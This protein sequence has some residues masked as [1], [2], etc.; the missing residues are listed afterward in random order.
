VT[1]TLR[2]VCALGSV[3]VAGEARAQDVTF[4]RDVAP[5]VFEACAP[6]HRP[7]GPGPFSLTTYQDVRRRATQI[8]EVTRRRFMPPWKV[9]PSVGHFVGQ[10]PLTDREIGVIER[11]AASGA[12]EGDPARVP[13]LPAFADRW[14]LGTPDLVVTP[15]APFLLPAEQVDVFR[16]FAIR[17]PVTRRTYVTGI[18]FHPG[19]ARVVHHANIR[20]DRTDATRRLDEADPLPGYDGLMPRSAAYP[21]GHFLGWTP[22]QVAPLVPA[23]LAW[24]LEPGS[25]LVVQLHM[26]PSGA[27]EAVLPEIGFYFSDQ[28]PRRTPTILRL[29][30]QGIDIPAGDATYVIHDSYVLPVDV[31]LLA[32][33][34]HAHY[35]AREILGIAELPDGSSRPVM[36]IPDWDFRWQHVYRYRTP[37]R[38]PRGTR[39]SMR[40]TYDNSAANPRNPERPPARVFWGQRSR[41]EM[42]DLWFQLLA[43]NDRDRAQL[44]AEIAAKMTAEDITGYETML[45]VTPGDAELHDDVAM[46]YLT[47]GMAANAVRHFEVSAALQ[48][49]S[50]AAHFNLGTALAQTGRLDAAVA[51]LEEALRRRPDYARAHGNLGR[52][53]LAQGKAADALEHLEAAVRLE[54]A[55]P[56]S[57]L[58]LAEAYAAS[59]AYD[60]AIEQLERASRLPVTEDLAKE[61]RARRAAYVKLRQG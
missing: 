57:L 30:S 14:L 6:C 11:W 21:D 10:R 12:P 28:P 4:A 56:T 26:Q 13:A 45:K 5:L 37:I 20:I 48:P 32:V 42:G 8:V 1:H 55:N 34:P 44:D 51:S 24:T 2:I 33:Q 15:E 17:V 53:L 49:E 52:V 29:G 7:N 54:P 58:G 22:G 31:E 38:L 18:E 61:I 23:D 9:E 41:D 25:D 36:R 39:L 60:L 50:A 16:I 3:I 43:A 19:N 40:Y 59:G 47:M 35:R 46:L 27:V